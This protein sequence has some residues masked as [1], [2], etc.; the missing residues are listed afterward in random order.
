VAESPPSGPSLQASVRPVPS[1]PV[2]SQPTSPQ[3]ARAQPA[4]VRPAPPPMPD[5][6]DL[7]EAVGGVAAKRAVPA[8]TALVLVALIIRWLLRRPRRSLDLGDGRAE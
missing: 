5:E 7:L 2:V 4:P 3:P 8:I 1:Q 6:I